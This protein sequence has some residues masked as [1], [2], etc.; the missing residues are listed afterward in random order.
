MFN[1]Q[2]NILITLH[3]KDDES[4]VHDVRHQY[5]CHKNG[6]K[7]STLLSAFI[8]NYY[9]E[10]EPEVELIINSFILSYLV[11]SDKCRI[12]TICWEIFDKNVTSI[13]NH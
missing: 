8:S 9:H 3:S 1:F 12:I 11:Y 4:D 7:I 6:N 10:I 5:L 13:S 2:N